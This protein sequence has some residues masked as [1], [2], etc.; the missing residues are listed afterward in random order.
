MNAS[1]AEGK[2]KNEGKLDANARAD[3][4][5]TYKNEEKVVDTVVNKFT[6][7]GVAKVEHKGE[8]DTEKVMDRIRGLLE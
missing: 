5:K 2:D 4:W 7:T 8:Q 1:E 3:I 6:G